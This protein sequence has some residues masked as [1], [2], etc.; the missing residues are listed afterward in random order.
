MSVIRQAFAKKGNSSLHVDVPILPRKNDR[1][2]ITNDIHWVIFVHL[3]KK[4]KGTLLVIFSNILKSQKSHLHQW[5]PENNSLILL[6][7]AI[8][9]Y[10]KYP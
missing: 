10:C 9:V 5:K 1:M 7:V 4:L 2:G 8:L 3:Y 6:K